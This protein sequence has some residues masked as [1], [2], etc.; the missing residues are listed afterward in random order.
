M[1]LT[2]AQSERLSKAVET[3]ESKTSVEVVLTVLP[4]STTSLGTSA[5][6]GALAA[7]V[8]LTLILFLEDVELDPELVVPAV[9]LAGAL[10]FALVSVLPA[11]WVSSARA[12]AL[13]VDTAA[14][15][16]FSRHGVYKTSGRTGVLVLLSL[17]EGE[18]RV[19]CDQ[20]VLTA[21]PAEVRAEWHAE[22]S[23]VARRF[24]VDAL[25]RALEALGARA[26][27][28]LPRQADD[29]DELANVPR[30]ETV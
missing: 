20:G 12:R 22:L 30:E 14:H 7:F 16:A 6:I 24:D 4:R 8:A 13:A 18:A 3:A 25:A 27:V 26:G 21:V 11:R 2:S 19:L 17:R 1:K 28:Y 10:T 9:G 15:A 23:G 29:V 5:V